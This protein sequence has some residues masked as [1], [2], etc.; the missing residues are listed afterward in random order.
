MSRSSLAGPYVITDPLLLA[1][2]EL[3]D[4]V[5]LAIQGGAALIQYRHK[6]QGRAT[7][8][9]QVEDLAGLCREQGVPLIIND[10][11]ELA[12]SCGADGVHIGRSDA[13]IAQ[14]RER[15]G[16]GAI[17][18]VSCYDELDRA[19]RAEAAGADYVAFGSVFPS[20]TKPQAHRASLALIR[21]ARERLSTPVCAIGGITADNACAVIEAGADM[22]AVISAVFGT[23][24]PRAAT[25]RLAAL[26]G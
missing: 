24:D 11:V 6:R 15:L 22:V 23:P 20:P 21:Q 1:P 17:I 14:A 19:L 13:P 12:R 7:H 8:R 25:G 2:G 18:G 5:G 3:L 10:E 26:F 16:P 9:Q 4:A